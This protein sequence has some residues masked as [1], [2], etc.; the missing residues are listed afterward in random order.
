MKNKAPQKGQLWTI[1]GILVVRL[2]NV[3]DGIATFHH[4]GAK[5]RVKVSN[6]RPATGEQVKEYLGK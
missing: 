4:H 6:L 5:G 1:K 2:S 3:Q